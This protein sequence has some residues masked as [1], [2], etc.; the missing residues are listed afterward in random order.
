[1][2][3]LFE[4]CRDVLVK[5]E[6]SGIVQVDGAMR[7]QPLHDFRLVVVVGPSERRRVEGVVAVARV[8][9]AFDKAPDH[10]EI[11]GKR[12]AVQRRTI[13]DADHVPVAVFLQEEVDG[14]SLLPYVGIEQRQ[15]DRVASG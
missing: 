5:I 1:M 10:V 13:V 4:P 9:A 3:I 6:R 14:L 12:R 7:P 2:P 8:G 11:T 15:P